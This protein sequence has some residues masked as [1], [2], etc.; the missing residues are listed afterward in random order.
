MQRL[1]VVAALVAAAASL[2][3]GVEAAL[4]HSSTTPKLAGTVGPGFTIKLT[5][6][7][8]KVTTLKAD[9]YL[10]VVADKASIHNF[11]LQRL[12]GGALT[13]VLT[14]T[15]FQGTKSITVKL[16]KGKWEYYCSVHKAL[17]HGFFTVT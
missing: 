6:G 4:G 7:G 12:S 16:G 15:S 9:S 14:A 13:K 17:M 10:F 11:T 2:T 8:Q 3:G 5:K 1:F